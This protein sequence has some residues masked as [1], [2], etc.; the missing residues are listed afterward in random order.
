MFSPGYTVASMCASEDDI[1]CVLNGPASAINGV[2]YRFGEISQ[3]PSQYMSMGGRSMALVDGILY[4][5]LTSE[6]GNAAAVWV[7]NEM[8][9]LKINGFISHISVN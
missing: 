4:V 8:K 2:I 1:C 3:I 9:P 7:D 6:S 5:G